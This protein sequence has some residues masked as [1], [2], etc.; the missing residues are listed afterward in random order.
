[1]QEMTSRE[2]VVAAFNH[3]LSDRTPIWCGMSAEFFEKAKCELGLDGEQLL[4]RF[5]DD[6]RRVHARYTGPK[7]PFTDPESHTRTVF[8]IERKGIGYGHGISI[9]LQDASMENVENY[10][11]PDPDWM[12]ISRFRGEIGQW[13]AQYAIMGGEWCPFWH[14]VIDLLGMEDMYI[15]MYEDPELVDAVFKKVVDYYYAVN[16]RIFTEAADLMDI[17]FMGNDFGSQT[18]PL[19][20]PDMFRRFIQPHLKRLIDQ[21]HSFGLKTQLHSCG[22]LMELIPCFMEAGLDALHALQPDCRCMEAQV[23]KD[24]FGDRLVLNGG[25]DSHHALIC[26]TPDSVR[27][28]TQ[29]ILDIMTPGGGYIAGASHDTILEETPVENVL[30]M[31]D[32]VK[33]FNAK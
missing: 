24:T 10:N 22:S 6:F 28:E 33:E 26:G 15:L 32:T 7:I 4:V 5:G 13:D 12:D 20:S 19:I 8:G 1:M 3:Q 30:A 21:A 9:P 17:F 16:Q 27:E 18:A 14:D 29:R 11:W 31:F 25:I 23:L 2:R